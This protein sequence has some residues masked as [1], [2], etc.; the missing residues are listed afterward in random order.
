MYN[1]R[2]NG[3]YYTT[4]FN[5]FKLDPFREWMAS[6]TLEK[7]TILEPFAGSNAIITML[8]SVGFAR[9]YRSYDIYPQSPEVRKRDTLADYPSGYTVCITNP[10]WLYKSSAHRRGLAFPATNYD[11]LYKLC[12]STSLKQNEYVG[13]L[14]PASFIQCG[15]FTDRLERVLF[16][17]KPLFTNTENPV[18]LALFGPARSTI[19]IYND[20]SYIGSYFQLKKCLPP[21]SKNSN[22]KFNVPTGQLG[23]VAID[24]HREPSIQFCD[25]EELKNHVIGHTSRA[26][27]RIGGVETG[28]QLLDRLNTCIRDI[29][30]KTK[31]TFLTPFK[32]L[33]KDGKYRRR[34]EYSLARNIIHNA[35]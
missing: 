24:N 33:R 14:V 32:G 20:N 19:E 22:I 6:N 28:P 12:L 11:D 21:K 10:P 9:K 30:D 27:T 23:F 34:M 18:C 8:Q 1:I 3:I 17:N 7:E 25:G 4:L 26:I 5:P 29:R 31:D 13:A 35:K 2:E 15:L 16:L